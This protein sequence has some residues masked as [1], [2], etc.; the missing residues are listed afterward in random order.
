MLPKKFRLLKKK[1][2]EKIHKFGKF[3][4]QNF[5]AIKLVKNSLNVSRFGF[6]IGIKVSKKSTVRNKIKRRLR[7]SVRLKLK[8][9]KP[10]FDIVVFV[11]PEIAEKNYWEIDKAVEKI[12]EKAKLLKKS[13]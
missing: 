1:D 6:L 2:F 9:I 11:R 5:L 13:I 7:E 10:G 8:R 4:G 12:F 3:F